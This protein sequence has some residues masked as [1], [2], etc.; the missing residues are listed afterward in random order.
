MSCASLAQCRS[1]LS[2]SR[3]DRHINAS[4]GAAT[5]L[6]DISPA[7]IAQLDAGTWQYL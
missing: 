5:P 2:P 7:E 3:L 6:L 4:E 1:A